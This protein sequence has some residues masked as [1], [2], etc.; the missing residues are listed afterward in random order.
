MFP[1][2]YLPLISILPISI[3]CPVDVLDGRDE[4]EATKLPFT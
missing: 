1:E 2:V 4:E 3:F